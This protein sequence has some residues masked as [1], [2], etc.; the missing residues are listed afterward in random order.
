VLCH[1]RILL[2]GKSNDFSVACHKYQFMGWLNIER[3]VKLVINFESQAVRAIKSDKNG[4]DTAEYV[5]SSSP[6]L[7]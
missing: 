6:Q 7:W 3:D 1:T 4:N 5:A 2:S